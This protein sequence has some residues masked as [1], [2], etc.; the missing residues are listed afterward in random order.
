[1]HHPLFAPRSDAPHTATA[2]THVPPTATPFTAYRHHPA[3]HARDKDV[4]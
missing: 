3:P 4:A 2:A 1:M